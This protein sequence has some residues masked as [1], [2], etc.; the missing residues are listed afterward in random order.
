MLGETNSSD[1]L[2]LD[3]PAPLHAPACRHRLS[4]AWW[5][6]CPAGRALWQRCA[7]AGPGSELWGQEGCAAHGPVAEAPENYTAAWWASAVGREAW[8]ECEAGGFGSV[9]WNTHKCWLR[10]WAGRGGG[11]GL[12]DVGRDG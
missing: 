11:A 6:G 12:G 4:R 1:P 8:K 9:A 3:G 2:G 5:S 10:R 7:A